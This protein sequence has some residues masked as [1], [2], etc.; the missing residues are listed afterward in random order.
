MCVGIGTI[1]IVIQ[2]NSPLVI[3][4]EYQSNN[5][6]DK[7]QKTAFILIAEDINLFAAIYS[8]RILHNFPREYDKKGVL[9]ATF[10][11]P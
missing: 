2:E 1:P 3:A 7:K 4:N 6:V 8:H 10:D 5:R 9:F 11:R